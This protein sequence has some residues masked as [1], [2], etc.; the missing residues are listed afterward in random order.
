MGIVLHS[1]LTHWMIPEDWQ[2]RRPVMNVSGI[3]MS[4]DSKT[5]VLLQSP[6]Y[7]WPA[8]THA[9]VHLLHPLHPLLNLLV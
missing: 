1:V 4:C 8:T 9:N 2:V 6:H 7:S 5:V 3:F